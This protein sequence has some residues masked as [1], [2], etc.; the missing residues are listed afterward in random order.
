MY[1]LSVKSTLSL[2]KTVKSDAKT[3]QSYRLHVSW[4][5]KTSDSFWISFPS[6]A[7]VWL[8]NLGGQFRSET[9]PRKQWGR[10][11]NQQNQQLPAPHRAGTCSPV[12]APGAAS[13]T[14]PNSAGCRWEP[15]AEASD[16]RTRTRPACASGHCASGAS[17]RD[18]PG[19]R[20]WTDRSCPRGR[21]PAGVCFLFS[22]RL[23][24]VMFW[25]FGGAAF[26]KMDGLFFAVR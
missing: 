8:A 23:G 6:R 21:G 3:I 18:P 15:A 13:P 22:Y 11:K 10:N 12:A 5:K 16:F 7:E 20:T 14:T 19:S 1:H 24:C 9:K 17:R 26:G 25:R 4:T 2:N